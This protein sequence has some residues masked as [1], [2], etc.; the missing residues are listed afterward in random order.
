MEPDVNTGV[1]ADA[2]AAPAEETVEATEAPAE[3][4]AA[5]ETP[6]AE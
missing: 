3:E 1:P 4:A 6:A 5:E 2:A